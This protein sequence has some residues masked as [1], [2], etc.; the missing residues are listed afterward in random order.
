VTWLALQAEI[1]VDFQRLTP[2]MWTHWML[3]CP[4]RDEAARAADARDA[5]TRKIATLHALG[6][7]AEARKLES[8]QR[9]WKRRRAWR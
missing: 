9:A 6:R 4:T 3:R 8:Y 7:V 5:T 2:T 1:A